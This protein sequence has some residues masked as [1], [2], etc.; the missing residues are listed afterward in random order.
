[1]GILALVGASHDLRVYLATG[2]VSTGKYRLV[3]QG[4]DAWPWIAAWF[5]LAAILTVHGVYRILRSANLKPSNTSLQTD[6]QE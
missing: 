6:R 4:S 5:F 3:L 2:Q 1:M